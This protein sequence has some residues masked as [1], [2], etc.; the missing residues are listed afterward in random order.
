MPYLQSAAI[1]AVSYDES[2]LVLRAKFRADGKVM[3]YENVPLHIYDSLIFA[4]SVADFF[5]ENI[6]GTYPARESRADGTLSDSSAS[7]S[8]SRATSTNLL[9]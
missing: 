8:R 5:R 2:E 7:R 9:R 6:E 4:D 1:E 3:A